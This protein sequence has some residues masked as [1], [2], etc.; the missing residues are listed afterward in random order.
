[1]F[2]TQNLQQFRPRDNEPDDRQK[3]PYDFPRIIRECGNENKV[4]GE[5]L[6]R[7]LKLQH[8]Q[9]EKEV[10]KA[11]YNFITEPR[12]KLSD[13]VDENALKEQSMKFTMSRTMPKYNMNNE[14]VYNFDN[15][16]KN[17]NNYNYNNMNQYNNNNFNNS[18]NSNFNQGNNMN[19]QNNNFNNSQR[20]EQNKNFENNFFYKSS[21]RN[22]PLLQQS[23]RNV[24]LP[25]SPNQ[26]NNNNSNN[27]FNRT[28]NNYNDFNNNNQNN[29]NRSQSFPT[30][31]QKFEN[32]YFDNNY[33]QTFDKKNQRF[34]QTPYKIEYHHRQNHFNNPSSSV[35]DYMLYD[36]LNIN[37]TRP[38][39][40]YEKDNI[41]YRKY[42]P[43][44]YDYERSRFGDQTYN[45]Y[46]NEAMRSDISK[47][48]KYP[49]QYYY[50]PR[51]NPK[52]HTYENNY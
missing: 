18:I 41:Q 13:T 30:R 35:P 2:R 4:I 33:D 7:R 29:L 47:D 23:L 46:L 19:Y 36:D 11:R 27:S 1:M 39:Y 38:Y 3:S 51:F 6:D 40:F 49:P 44:I 10:V 34:I 32:Y 28:N 16:R 37:K 12:K 22:Q 31:N 42:S 48:W 52:T 15:E 26:N 20:F 45:Y 8:L 17:N 25:P 14:Q 43:Y 5:E 50:L 9:R 21:R 24:D